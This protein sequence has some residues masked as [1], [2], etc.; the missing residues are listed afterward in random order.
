[1]SNKIIREKRLEM[2]LSQKQLAQ[3]LGVSQQHLDRYEKGYQV[4]V[5]K[6]P[7]IANILK[8]DPWELLP[9]G[10]ARPQDVLSE[11]E[12]AIIQI[13]RSQK[14]KENNSITSSKTE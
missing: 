13:I 10:F 8:I 14:A 9:E 4:P 5:E 2:G 11:D 3:M 7:N 1:M 12:K 6:I